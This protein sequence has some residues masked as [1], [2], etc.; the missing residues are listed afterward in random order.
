MANPNHELLRQAI[1]RN[2]AA[3]LSLPSAGIIRNHKTRFLTATENG[4]WLES[5]PSDGPLLDELI[6]S[7]SPVGISF[8]GQ[9]HANVVFAAPIQRRQIDFAV[10]STTKVEA[11]FLPFPDA[12]R[13]NQRRA[14]YRVGLQQDQNVI[15]RMWRIAEHAVL[16]DRPMASQELVVRLNNISVMG[17]GMLCLP[18]RHK[19]MVRIMLAERVRVVLDCLGNE[20]LMEGRVIHLRPARNNHVLMGIQLKKLDK[21]IAAR[22]ALT[23]LSSLVA[24][25]QRDEIRRRRILAEAS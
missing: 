9:A 21:E 4:F 8:K 19:E 25:L 2:A 5:V 6:H 10:N 7:E 12:F 23:K 14:V 22:Q 24:H 17:M 11:L 1:E 16:R 20:I 15:M 18:N 13:Q 3:V